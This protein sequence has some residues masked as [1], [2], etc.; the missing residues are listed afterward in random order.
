MEQNPSQILEAETINIRKLLLK[1][2]SYW[3]WFVLSLVI[4]GAVAMLWI[5]SSQTSY[6]SYATLL[7]K[8]DGQSMALD[9]LLLNQTPKRNIANE[10][11]IIKSIHI[12]RK[13]LGYIP[14]GISYYVEEKLKTK[15]LYSNPPFHIEIDS[16]H[17]Q[18]YNVPVFINPQEQGKIHVKVE[19]EHVAFKKPGGTSTSIKP[20][21]IVD[22]VINPGEWL[23]TQHMAFKVD[24]LA[25][26]G[27][28]GSCFFVMNSVARQVGFY[29][30]LEVTMN[31]ESALLDLTL[32]TDDPQKSIDLLNALIK[33][34]L[35]SEI[36]QKLDQR[37][38]TIGF[39]DQLI[40]EISDTLDRYEN[41]L[42]DFQTEN[43][44]LGIE[45][46]SEDL[47]SKYSDLQSKLSQLSLQQRYYKYV[48]NLLE[49][50][51]TLSDLISP[52]TLGIN[53]PI[54]NDLVSQLIDL[55]NQKSEYA[56]NTRKDNPYINVID[57]KISNLQSSLLV[58]IN[59]NLEA[60]ELSR[61]EYEAQLQEIEK[62]L[63]KLPVT[64]K[65]LKTYERKFNVIDNLYTFLLKK[66]SEARIERSGTRPANE[67]IQYAT[68]LTTTPQK[69]SP[70]QVF[71]IAMVL[72]L[73]LPFGAIQ[74]KSVI[75]NKVEDEDQVRSVTEIPLLGQVLHVNKKNKDVFANPV[76][77]E[78]EAF[79]TLR[80]NL[81]FFAT[82]EPVKVV[83]VTSSKKGEGKS[84]VAHNLA[85]AYAYNKKRSLLLN[86]DL[87]K[88]HSNE[89]GL[90]N[91]LSNQ[92]SLD[93]I[94]QKNEPDLHYVGSGP[95]PPNAGE[96]ITSPLMNDL[97]EKIRNSYDLV[98]IDS[99]PLLPISDASILSD[100][101]DLQLFVV[102]LNYTPMDLF[103][104]SIRKQSFQNLKRPLV[105]LNDIQPRNSYYAYQYY[106]KGY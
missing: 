37:D 14:S 40:V 99:P 73:I 74:L 93:E 53:E 28:E 4:A 87:R 71:I 103:K 100:F 69:R 89:K 97:F 90:S 101:S 80:T 67:V 19:A 95:T 9:N 96:L 43:L 10:A 5:R 27:V 105:L 42:T 98:V 86:F 76:S 1:T 15:E 70:V 38:E 35:D 13:A 82:R 26:E 56:Y 2:I 62:K 11:G 94:L 55:Y 51:K 106:Q 22:T 66:R 48:G 50:E 36:E 58:N 54:I 46:K 61:E 92:A 44:T 32:E 52:A 20:E 102:R 57:E 39:I 65:K 12:K 83:L 41:Q 47:Y 77:T 31:K 16:L 64:N 23:V 34:Y 63:G 33:A 17:L 85:R 25:L 18:P 81:G 79:R 21:F 60:L 3:P 72:G 68:P 75:F 84:F 49:Q 104:Q 88:S 6:V 78:A 8:E 45:A 30:N 59:N 29:R 24:A 7:I 91:Y